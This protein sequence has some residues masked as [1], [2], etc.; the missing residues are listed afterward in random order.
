LIEV[1]ALADADRMRAVFVRFG[2]TS[3]ANAT[4]HE[5]DRCG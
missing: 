2:L 1:P 5:A 4:L 3:P